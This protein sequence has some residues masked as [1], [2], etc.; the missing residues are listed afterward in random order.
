[1]KDLGDRINEVWRRWVRENIDGRLLRRD[2]AD[3][4]DD[5]DL[6]LYLYVVVVLDGDV[7]SVETVEGPQAPDYFT[8]VSEMDGRT[9]LLAAVPVHRGMTKRDL[10]DFDIAE[11][12]AYWEMDLA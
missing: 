10:I 8:G 3:I 12:T 9:R 5:G 2:L 6:D 11:D 1:M 7:P 4:E